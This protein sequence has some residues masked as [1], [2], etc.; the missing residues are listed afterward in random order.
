MTNGLP[1]QLFV[2]SVLS[3]ASPSWAQTKSTCYNEG[4][5]S[6]EPVGDR[7][8]HTIT[9]SKAVCTS[10]GGGFDGI[11]MTQHAVWEGDKGTNTMVSAD[12]V[13]RRPGGIAVYRLSG[14]TLTVVLQDG[15]PVGW[16]G[17]GKG[18]YPVAGG[19]LSSIAGKPFSWTAK[20][21]GPRSF[22]IDSK[23][24]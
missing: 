20:S 16:T 15:K 14:G 6:I 17:S 12:G 3:L 18:T 21:T 11:V 22:V 8:G 7:E 13:M 19:N 5:T 24:D 1:L 9:L 10:E 4:A 23:L 2:I